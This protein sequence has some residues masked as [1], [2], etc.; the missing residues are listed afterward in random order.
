MS[1]VIAAL[2]SVA[3]YSIA[4]AMDSSGKKSFY[5]LYQSNLIHSA[6]S[7][8][9]VNNHTQANTLPSEFYGQV[10]IHEHSRREAPAL[11]ERTDYDRL[12]LRIP[13]EPNLAALSD[14]DTAI[15][16][17]VLSSSRELGLSSHFYE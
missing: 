4:F 7:F 9:A 14:P 8:V 5:D 6:A 2:I 13:S 12:I 17:S 10:I 16:P 11:P 1:R 3:A 15:K